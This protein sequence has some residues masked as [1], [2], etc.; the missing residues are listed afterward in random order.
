MNK[1]Q[2]WDV[3]GI[4]GIL[5]VIAG[6][7]FVYYEAE[8]CKNP[9]QTIVKQILENKNIT[10]F[11]YSYVKIEFYKEGLEFPVSKYMLNYDGSYRGEPI[12]NTKIELPKLNN[13]ILEK[14]TKK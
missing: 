10:D 14:I 3:I 2:T 7:I 6:G 9:L 5:I 13:T 1:K 8:Q 11:E 12:Q 4:I